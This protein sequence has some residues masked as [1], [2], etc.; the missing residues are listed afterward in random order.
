M[1]QDAWGLAILLGI[2]QGLSEFLPI[3]SSAHLIVFSWLAE[4]S[5]LPLSLNVAMHVGTLASLVIFFH[6]DWWYL[7]RRAL[8]RL[9]GG[10]ASFQA[11]VLLP[12]LV[13]GSIP[14]AIVG[15]L[16]KDAIEAY[17]HHP[18]MVIVPLVV[19]GFFLWWVDIKQTEKRPLDSITIK[20]SWFIGCAQAL[21]LIPG[22]SRSGI[23][24]IAGRYFGLDRGAAARFSFLLGT[25]AM[26]G[27]A[28]VHAGEI[29]EHIHEPLFYGGILVSCVVGCLAI[30]FLLAFINR[31]GFLAFALYRFVLGA[32]L[33]IIAVMQ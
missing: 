18:F 4:G 24:I 27:A 7:A 20:K 21:A 2:V 8:E 28:L 1:E 12:G 3:S 31:F 16:G 33:A 23:T 22:V 25:P 30:K 11:D 14:A 9:S 17:F 29:T 32:L 10:K 6:R 19:V 13:I 26:V 5:P 15:G